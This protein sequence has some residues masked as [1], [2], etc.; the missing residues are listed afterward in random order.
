MATVNTDKTVG[1]WLG[2]N[3]EDVHVY[4]DKNVGAVIGQNKKDDKNGSNLAVSLK[5]ET[6][7]YQ[8]HENG[9][10]KIVE[11]DKED[12]RQALLVFLNGLKA[13]LK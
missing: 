12:F 5:D 8:Y 4:V 7:T 9:Q 6:V 1:T 11:L 13:L 3:G 2:N 10:V